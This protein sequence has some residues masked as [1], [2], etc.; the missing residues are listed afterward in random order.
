MKGF[1]LLL[2]AFAILFSLFLSGWLNRGGAQVEARLVPK[3]PPSRD[4]NSE[5]VSDLQVDNKS[6]YK[7]FNSSFRGI[8]PSR[9]NPTQNKCKPRR[10]CWRF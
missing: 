7:E 6:S 5:S 2:A 10:F 3:P 9:S 1:S 4:T 8:P